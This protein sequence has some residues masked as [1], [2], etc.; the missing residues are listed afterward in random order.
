MRSMESNKLYFGNPNDT[1]CPTLLPREKL[2]RYG[3]QSLELW[4]LLAVLLRTGT[5]SKHHTENVQ[6]LAQ[7]LLRDGGFRGLF[8][9]TDLLR[10]KELFGIYTSHAYQLVTVSEI[11]RRLNHT[12]DPFDAGTP[13]KIAIKYNFLQQAHQEQCHVLH[14]NDKHQAVH[15]ELVAT[16]GQH[17]VTVT[18]NQILKSALWLGAEKIVILH[19]H[20]QGPAKPSPQD[21]QWTLRLVEG[22][23]SLHQ[24]E[25]IDHIIINANDYFSFREKG[26]LGVVT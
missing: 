4:E 7:R 11:V 19:N 13:E 15:Q 5:R 14:L 1:P 24:I 22:A 21:I 9:Q 3:P 25:L 12:A 10:A 16:G 8:D 6:L 23:R 26:L 17:Q 2:E 20:P 18:P